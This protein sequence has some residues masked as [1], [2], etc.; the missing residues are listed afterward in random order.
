MSDLRQRIIL[1]HKLRQ[2]AG[3]KELLHRRRDWLGIN[4]VL[5]H[6]AFA[7]SHRETLFNS[8]LY[9][10]ETDSELILSHF[11]NRSNAA[12]TQMINIIHHAFTI[13]NADQRAHHIDDIVFV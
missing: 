2:L 5:R 13:S 12:V 11:A 7:L 9:P 1:V 3:T 6:E 10:N 8:T 4:E